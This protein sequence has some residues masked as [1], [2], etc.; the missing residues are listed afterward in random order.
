MELDIIKNSDPEVAEYIEKELQRER[1]DFD[2]ET[3]KG[4][5]DPNWKMLVPLLIF[6]VSVLIFGLHSAPIVSF[7][8]DV[9][10]GMY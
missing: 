1:E 10:A 3:V 8:K 6:S 5:T 4:I 7:F 9:A 2:R